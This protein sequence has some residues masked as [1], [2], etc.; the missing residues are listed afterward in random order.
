[1]F[2][3]KVLRRLFAPKRDKVTKAGENLH[4][5]ELH[6]L[7]CSPDIIKVIKLRKKRRRGHVA[8]MR[9]MKRHAKFWLGSLM[10]IDHLEGLGIGGSIILKQIFGKSG[11][12]VWI[13]LMWLKVR[14]G[15][16]LL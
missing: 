11:L 9:E 7:Y 3:N 14:T 8:H 12:G 15:G 5:D 16:R 4:N 1:M 2:E 6:S 13:G 10:E